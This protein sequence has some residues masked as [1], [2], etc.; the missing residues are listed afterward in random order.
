VKCLLHTLPCV[1]ERPSG[2]LSFQSDLSRAFSLLHLFDEMSEK[3]S[4]LKFDMGSVTAIGYFAALVKFSVRQQER[5]ALANTFS[6]T[7]DIMGLQSPGNLLLNLVYMCVS[8]C[9][10]QTIVSTVEKNVKRVKITITKWTSV[11]VSLSPSVLLQL[12]PRMHLD[13]EERYLSELR[14]TKH[15]RFIRTIE[16]PRTPRSWEWNG[17]N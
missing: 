11:C 10:L 4:G 15:E 14:S 6:T 12:K 5:E 13:H 9:D 17:M 1:A 3:Q 16:A 8:W 2:M 7:D